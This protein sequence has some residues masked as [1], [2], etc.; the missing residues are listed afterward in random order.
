MSLDPMRRAGEVNLTNSRIGS[1]SVL[2]RVSIR[3]T[4]AGLGNFGEQGFAS[5]MLDDGG[6]PD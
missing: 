4:G 1:P 6:L 3:T 2:V 5:A